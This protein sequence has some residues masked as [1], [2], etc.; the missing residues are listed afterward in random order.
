MI[1]KNPHSA[2]QSNLIEGLKLA[3]PASILLWSLI[4]TLVL[5]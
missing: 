4:L 3:I 1:Q 2:S 5:S